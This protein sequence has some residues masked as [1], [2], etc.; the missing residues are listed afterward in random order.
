M[1][2]AQKQ[3]AEAER[4]AQSSISKL[5]KAMAMVDELKS[6]KTDVANLKYQTTQSEQQRM[7]DIQS[8]ESQKQDLQN[9]YSKFVESNNKQ[10]A[11]LHSQIA[12]LRKQ[13]A[14]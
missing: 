8:F 11:D 12:K 5:E 10:K 4:Q 14:N 7:T 2:K 1:D 9:Q 13:L 3:V 6:L